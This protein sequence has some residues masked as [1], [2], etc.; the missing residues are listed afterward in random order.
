[1]AR[2]VKRVKQKNTE[3]ADVLGLIDMAKLEEVKQETIQTLSVEDVL[4]KYKGYVVKMTNLRKIEKLFD[5][6]IV[7]GIISID[8]E[9]NNSVEART[10]IMVGVCLYTPFRRPVYIPCAHRDKLTGELVPG[11][12][13]FSFLKEQFQRIKDAQVK[14]VW[15]NAKFDVNVIDTNCGIRL[16][17]YWD[18]MVAAKLLDENI[19][20]ARLKD[21]YRLLIEPAQPTYGITKLFEAN[22]TAD[23]DKFTLYS[24]VDPFDTYKLYEYQKKILEYPSMSK[25]LGLFLNIEMR[26]CEIACEMEQEGAH[27]DADL[28]RNYLEYWKNLADRYKEKILNFF[29][30]VKSKVEEWPINIV[31]T[32]Q[33]RDAF[34]AMNIH[35]DDTTSESLTAL[36]KEIP[37]ANDIVEYRSANHMVTSFFGPLLEQINPKTGRIHAS[38]NQLGTEDKTIKTGRFSCVQPNLQQLPSFDDSVRL[39]FNGGI[40][41][42]LVEIDDDEEI[43]LYKEDL[44]DTVNGRILAK[45]LEIGTE[46]LDSDSVLHR[47]TYLSKISKDKVVIKID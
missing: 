43:V 44:L 16:P 22:E 38:F 23:I 3:I 14:T 10:A 39:C 46:I 1:M 19:K 28:C 34:A 35:V 30:P 32:D 7:N 25:V 41:D 42:E 21:L 29:S 4:R 11:Q 36:S 15:H 13:S 6:A 2:V 8:T 5:Q 37:I 9:T 27:I 20:S 26:I 12:V 24:A 45:D 31:S 18:T 33:V 47:I 40:T 17:A